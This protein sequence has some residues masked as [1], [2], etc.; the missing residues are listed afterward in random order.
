MEGRK[1]E[2]MSV[3]EERREGKE[4]DEEEAEK[5]RMFALDKEKYDSLI[6]EGGLRVRNSRVQKIVCSQPGR[7]Q[8]AVKSSCVNSRDLR[9]THYREC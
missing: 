1:K 4:K 3:R 2:K 9:G 6:C 7:A 8:T 5:Q